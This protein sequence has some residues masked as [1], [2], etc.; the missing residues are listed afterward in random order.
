VLSD[1][2]TKKTSSLIT[3]IL[4]LVAVFSVATGSPILSNASSEDDGWVEG[5]YEGSL[6]EQEEQAQEDW[7]DAGRPGEIDDNENDD[8]ENNDEDDNDIDEKPYCDEVDSDYSGSCFDRYDYSD[9][10]GLY[11]CKDGSQVTDPLDCGSS[12]EPEI[13]MNELGGTASCLYDTSLPQCMPL[14]GECQDG[15]GMNED[16]R[17]F[18]EHSKCPDGYHGHEDDETG[19]CIPNNIPCAQGYVMTVMTNGGDNCEQKQQQISCVDVPF[20]LTC[21]SQK[22]NDNSNGGPNIGSST[23]T[24]NIV[25]NPTPATSTPETTTA[26][27]ADISNCKLD[28]SADGIQQKFDTAKYQ[29]CKLYTNNDKVYYDG[30]VAG[31]MNIGNTKLICQTVADNSI[32]NMNMPSMQKPTT[33]P[34]STQ[35]IQPTASN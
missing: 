35:A 26:N 20:Y 11:P 29:A 14:N 21:D 12:S 16:G 32:L 25:I 4:L 18:P 1:Y 28:G 30:F 31:C 22:K 5:D 10:T 23:T 33:I 9:T 6:E 17:C 19:E 13:Q 7:E 34:Q 3:L 24:K 2:T 8:E 27:A 15:Y